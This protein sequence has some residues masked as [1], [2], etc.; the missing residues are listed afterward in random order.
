MQTRW[1]R[2]ARQQNC[3]R[4]FKRRAKRSRTRAVTAVR[5]YVRRRESRVAQEGCEGQVKAKQ[6]VVPGGSSEAARR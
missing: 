2:R 5:G 4:T 3:A 1:R 6:A